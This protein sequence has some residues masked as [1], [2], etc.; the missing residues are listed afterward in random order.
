MPFCVLV[1]LLYSF[2]HT[3]SRFLSL[4][5]A[6]AII[7]DHSYGIW[8]QKPSKSSELVKLSFHTFQSSAAFENIQNAIKELDEKST[9]VAAAIIKIALDNRLCRFSLFQQNLVMPFL[10]HTSV[11]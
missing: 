1:C 11:Q 6:T 3:L 7:A 9:E 5:T 2:W 10:T 4:N 8:R